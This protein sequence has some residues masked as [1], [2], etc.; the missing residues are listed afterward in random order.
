[1]LLLFDFLVKAVSYFS[2]II[3]ENKICAFNIF[4]TANSKYKCRYTI[5]YIYQLLNFK[6]V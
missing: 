6:I 5:Y 3:D 2:L 1:M 4:I